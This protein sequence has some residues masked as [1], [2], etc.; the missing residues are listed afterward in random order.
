[1]KVTIYFFDPVTKQ[2]TGSSKEY[3]VDDDLPLENEKI[4]AA[5]K[6]PLPMLGSI[7]K[8]NSPNDIFDGY[9]W[10]AGPTI[11]PKRI[12]T[13]LEEGALTAEGAARVL[14]APSIVP[15]LSLL[16]DKRLQRKSKVFEKKY[17]TTERESWAQQL[18]E[19][20]ALEDDPKA[21]TPILSAVAEAENSSAEEV[22]LTVLDKHR[23]YVEA[24]AKFVADANKL[25]RAKKKA[26]E[27][28]DPTKVLY[29][30]SQLIK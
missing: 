6:L 18:T 7:W 21:E 11:T 28:K 30:L 9:G 20:R 10:I 17:S 4:W 22:A 29:G 2:P 26:L 12:A 25:R 1:M 23:E 8:P 5:V 13:L 15:E 24:Q 16:V 27:E 14:P 3:E 19:A